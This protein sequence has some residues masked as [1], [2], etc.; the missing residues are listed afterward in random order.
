VVAR[1]YP[2]ASHY[3]D[4]AG[5]RLHYLDEGRGDPVVMVHGNPT[6]S[7]YYRNLVAALQARF[8]CVVPDHVGCGLS[9][10]PQSHRYD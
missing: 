4:R 1:P 10:K 6:W 2:F 9:D 8:R 3:F 7:Y 5:I